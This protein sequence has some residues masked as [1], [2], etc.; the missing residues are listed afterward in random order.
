[1]RRWGGA[2]HDSHPAVAASNC[3][4]VLLPSNNELALLSRNLPTASATFATAVRQR[5][6][7]RLVLRRDARV[8]AAGGDID[9]VPDQFQRRLSRRPAPRWWQ[10]L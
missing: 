2:N 10:L 8:T 7:R 4:F 6:L 3:Q 1:M 9:P 5:P